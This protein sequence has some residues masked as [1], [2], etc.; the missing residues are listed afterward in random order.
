MESNVCNISTSMLPIPEEIIT[1]VRDL[2]LADYQ[3]AI[4][5]SL[6]ILRRLPGVCFV[7]QFGAVN[8]PGVSDI[9]LLV[10]VRDEN[11]MTVYEKSKRIPNEIPNGAYLFVDSIAVI[12]YSIARVARVLHSFKNLRILWGDSSILDL[13]KESAFPIML[14]NAIIWNSHLWDAAARL[15]VHRQS[16]RPLLL[17]LGNFVQS[18]ASNYELLCETTKSQLTLDWGNDARL[19]ILAAPPEKRCDLVVHYLW[20]AL[21][22]L[23]EADWALQEWWMRTVRPQAWD[24]D[25]FEL[26]LGPRVVAQLR[27]G[28]K[29]DSGNRYP[30]S[31]FIDGN[32][33]QFN[34]TITLALPSFYLEIVLAVK[35]AFDPW[36]N[37]PHFER[38]TKIIDLSF[39]DIAPWKEAILIYTKT[40][41][42]LRQ[43]SRENDLDELEMYR[44]IS[45]LPFGQQG[46][47]KRK[48]LSINIL[49]AAVC[50]VIGWG[51]VDN[52]PNTQHPSHLTK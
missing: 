32:A 39:L 18:T 7:G 3:Q 9:D 24:V 11:F 15:C 31:S 14:I 19:S 8:T 2:V 41:E 50:K 5:L 22:R 52:P 12:P 13:L 33:R 25:T 38:A 36:L 27:Q 48:N 29:N 51:T 30:L 17:G 6:E 46:L 49:K 4:D 44:Q 26:P 42:S 16:L 23:L 1:D 21:S 34:G 45:C 43:F 40:V 35:S 20:E 28:N 37:F 47:E 10:I